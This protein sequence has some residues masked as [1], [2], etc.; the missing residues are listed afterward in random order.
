MPPGSIPDKSIGA[1]IGAYPGLVLIG[2][3]HYLSSGKGSAA[4]GAATVA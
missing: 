2:P 4:V 3:V 1:A